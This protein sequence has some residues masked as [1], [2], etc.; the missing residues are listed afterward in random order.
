MSNVLPINVQTLLERSRIESHR[1]ELR[2][3]WDAD[4]V[5]WQIL[6][7]ICAFANDHYN[8]NGGYVVID[9]DDADGQAA[10]ATSG[11]SRQKMRE[12]QQWIREHCSCLDPAY[13]PILS[14]EVVGGRDLLVVWAPASDLRP[15]RAPDGAY[16]S[17]KY[18]I[19]QGSE[20]VD[21]QQRGVLRHLIEPA[22]RVPWDNRRG[23]DASMADL[24]EE[25]VREY[26]RDVRSGLGDISSTADI[27][28][29]MQ[30]TRQ[31]DNQEVPRNVGLLFFAED[32]TAWF[33]GAKIEVVR[34][35]EDQ[36]GDVQEERA[37]KGPLAD[38]LRDCLRH[39][40]G[41]SE[42]HL[43]KDTGGPQARRWVS[44]PL[45]AVRESL[46]NAVCHRSY[47]PDNPD[48]TKVYLYPDRMEIISYPGPAPGIDA[49]HLLP[50]AAVPHV[51]ARNQRVG[52][53]L[54]ELG[55]AEGRLT[56]IR[57][58]FQALQ[59]NGSPTP[60]FD[61][62]SSRS[63]FRATLPA[64]PEFKAINALRDAAHLRAL[65]DDL[66]AS[67]RVQSA[68]K[69]NPGSGLL[70][71]ELIRMYGRQ[72]RPEKSEEVF[73]AFKQ[74]SSATA[75]AHV[76]NVLVES[77][78]DCGAN[79]KAERL[80]D[81]IPAVMIG[82][83]AIDAGIM[84]RRLS[85]PRRAERF[86]ENAGEALQADP[87]GLHEYAQAKLDSSRKGCCDGNRVANKR[88]LLEARQLLERVIQLDASPTRHAWAW[89][90][91]ARTRDWLG[92]PAR[93]VEE[94]YEQA[95]Q[96]LPD[97]PRFKNELEAVMAK[98][99]YPRGRVYQEAGRC[100]AE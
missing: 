63:Y 14:A 83:D 8:L 59:D 66:S 94:A 65:G 91:L 97:E 10:S 48:P 23:F 21:A 81:K 89:R 76:T 19:R 26:L 79:S 86:F 47:Q 68:W 18:W 25:R 51:P 39:L 78:F 52:E 61:F 17:L 38:Q 9:V 67:R 62:D 100:H 2:T 6:K 87:R 77:L 32:P 4:T 64:H 7:T 54:K 60:K 28:R 92:E 16:G 50:G 33:H 35:V 96:L 5:G 98:R 58:V 30:I 75:I 44:Y 84:A 13:A 31:V 72:D 37:F 1:I 93:S 40:Q 74:D 88:L 42:T 27:C 73:E 41:L 15:H 55:L 82:Q 46:V 49:D 24:R 43:V 90:D 80:L 69:A 99:S 29:R 95:M 45:D 34:F 85:D 3:V 53:F 70:T 12:A 36:V 56:G 11:I 57:K 22:A 71:A 20:T